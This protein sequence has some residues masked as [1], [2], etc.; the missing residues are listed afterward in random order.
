MSQD[1]FQELKQL[2]QRM[3][4]ILEQSVQ[5]GPSAEES[6]AP[7]SERAWTPVVDILETAEEFVVK[8]EL[9]EVQREDVKLQLTGNVLTLSGQRR[10]QP[11]AEGEVVHHQRER[12]WGRFIRHFNLPGHL[13]SD[14]IS[15]LLRD[16]VLTIRLAKQRELSPRRI[17]IS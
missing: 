14:T 9:P 15:A 7:S 2:Q 16:G 4:Q 8:A 6:S 3:K 1:P 17:E 10:R 13:D 11:R 12:A 5:S